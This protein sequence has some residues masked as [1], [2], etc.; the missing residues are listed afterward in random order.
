MYHDGDLCLFTESGEIV[1]NA[2]HC[3]VFPTGMDASVGKRIQCRF[4]VIA[5][6]E[7]AEIVDA[8]EQ[9]VR[10]LPSPAQVIEYDYDPDDYAPIVRDDEEEW[11]AMEG[12][13]PDCV[14]ELCPICGERR[15]LGCEAEEC[16]CPC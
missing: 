15:T 3:M 13:C 9:A 14:Q 5:N 10:A 4:T 12:L 6:L 7:V 11:D 2:E 1:D 8:D 16:D